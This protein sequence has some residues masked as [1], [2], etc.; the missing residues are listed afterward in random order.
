[1]EKENAGAAVAEK[2]EQKQVNI[3]E[4]FN[5]IGKRETVAYI[6]NDVSNTFGIGYGDRYIWDVVHID[7]TVSAVVNLFTSAWDIINDLL[8]ATI[9]DNTRTRIGK[10]R[11]YLLGMQIPLTLLG[12]LYWMLPV[13]FPNTSG[14]YIPKLIFYFTFNIIQ[15]TAG[16]AISLA[17]GGY[18]STITPNPNERVRMIMLAELLS[19]YLGE[20]VPGYIMGILFDLVVNEKI[21][22]NLKKP[23][24]LMHDAVF[25]LLLQGESAAVGGG[26]EHK[27][28]HE[29]DIHELPGAVDVPVRLPRRLRHKRLHAELFY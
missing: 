1:M 13:F 28:G 17:K 7:F 16:T 21:N 12:M 4:N 6:L 24:F 15:E 18:M 26:T 10:F 8:L 22:L 5:Y 20:D 9:V 27:R 29:G 25:L 2:E 23:Y 11:P 19:G 3:F 14:T